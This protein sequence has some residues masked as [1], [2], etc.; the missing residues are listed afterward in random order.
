MKRYFFSLLLL[1]VASVALAQSPPDTT[2]APDTLATPAPT[3][4]TPPPPPPPAVNTQST[5]PPPSDITTTETPAQS[6]KPSRLYYG[7]SIGF[8]LWGDVRRVSIEPLIG[9]KVSPRLSLGIK[10]MYE[11]LTDKSGPT[12]LTYD[13]Y[14]ASVFSRL[15]LT[16]RFYGQAEFEMVSYDFVNGRDTVPFLLVGGGVVQPMGRNVGLTAE[17]MVDVLNDDKSPYNDFEPQ[18]SVGVGVG[19]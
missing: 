2:Q 1:G 16:P 19:F 18:V 15:R 4:T 7:G 9:Y 10:P 8:S 12:D 5:T 17:V 11:H 3:I 14:G 6:N 13:N